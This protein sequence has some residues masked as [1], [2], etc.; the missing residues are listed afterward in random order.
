MEK[1]ANTFFYGS[2]VRDG[3]VGNNNWLPSTG[4]Y[5]QPRITGHIYIAGDSGTIVEDNES[6]VN[7]EAIVF[8][9]NRWKRLGT[10][11]SGGRH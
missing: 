5:P 7:G 10:S 9:E 11:G 8:Q 1:N 3:R 6:Y 4:L 2:D